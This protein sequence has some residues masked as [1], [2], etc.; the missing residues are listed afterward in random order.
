M[1]RLGTIVA[2]AA[3]ALLLALAAPAAPAREPLD[4]TVF[5]RIGPPGQPEPVAVG[6]DDRVYVGTNQLGHGDARAP[7]KVFAFSQA[8]ELV[9]EY[10]LEGQPLEEDHGIQGLVFDRD[11]LLYALD[12]SADPRVVVLDPATG[13]QRVYARFRDVPSC[14]TAPGTE[15]RDCSDTRRD[16]PAGPDYAVFAPDGDLYVTDIDQALIWKVPK[17]GGEASVWLTDA[18]LESLYGPNGIQFLADERTLLF[19]NTASNPS[20]G[21]AATGRLYTVPVQPDGS[22]GELKQVWESRPVDAPDGIAIARSGNVYVAL[23]GSSQVLKLSPEYEELA[24]APRDPAANDQEEVPLDG[25]GSLAFLGDRLLVSNH[26]PIRGDPDSW[27]ILDVFAGEPGLPLHYP[28][29]ATPRLSVRILDH[30][31]F[32]RAERARVE[33]TRHLASREVPVRGATVRAGRARARTGAR[34]RATLRLPR[35]RRPTPVT[36]TREGFEEARATLG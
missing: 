33:V 35:L 31:V 36:A 22:P 19:V 2:L 34:G 16:V 11:G 8:G 10:V 23:A 12:R 26:S 21:N 1:T 25:P 30:R 32:R 3:A 20:A 14:G 4:I 29:I 18:R 13:E 17:G 6:P 28:R 15:G 5:T 7:S 24:R 9:R 27:A